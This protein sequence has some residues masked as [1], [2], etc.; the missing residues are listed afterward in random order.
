MSERK[1]K[2]PL[3]ERVKAF[4]VVQPR[5]RNILQLVASYRLVSAEQV[6]RMLSIYPT[7]ARQRLMLMFHNGYLDREREPLGRG[8][9]ASQPVYR[10]T[11]AG[12]KE[13]GLTGADRRAKDV[14]PQFI[15]HKLAIN[16]VRIAITL[17]AAKAGYDLEEWRTEEELKSEA[18]RDYVTIKKKHGGSEKVAVIADGFFV[19]KVPKGRARSF[20]EVDQGTESGAGKWREKVLAYIQYWKS[21]K[22]EA[23]YKSQS[24]RVVT[25]TKSQE[26]LKTIKK[27]TE[28]ACKDAD[29][30][31]LTEFFLFTTMD[32]VSP[33]KVFHSPIWLAG[34]KMT[35]TLLF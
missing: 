14:G 17:A 13:A 33:E 10:I 12:R 27:V 28:Q 29:S 31:E 19:I 6:S 34:G 3:Y 23:H 2:K 11:A 8:S 26:H 22:Y 18:G 24:F 32:Q 1:K 30:Q 35:P 9:F 16:N 20:L 7:K 25:V 15:R 21:G 4:M 5:D